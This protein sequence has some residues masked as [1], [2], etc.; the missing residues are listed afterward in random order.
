MV[1][2]DIVAVV[3]TLCQF[4]LKEMDVA[5]AETKPLEEFKKS[6]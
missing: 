3:V 4:W 5:G 2:F 6:K 1:S